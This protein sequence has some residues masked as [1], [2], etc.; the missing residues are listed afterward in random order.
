MSSQDE[1]RR[2][3]SPTRFFFVSGLSISTGTISK[4]VRLPTYIE[5]RQSKQHYLTAK[6]LTLKV[7][8]W[9]RGEQ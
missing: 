7:N 4:E 6:Y 1:K 3:H 2:P 8:D 9:S 5:A